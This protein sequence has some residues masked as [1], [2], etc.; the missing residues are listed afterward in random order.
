MTT[1]CRLE[2][3][4]QLGVDVNLVMFTVIAIVTEEHDKRP[5]ETADLFETSV[6]TGGVS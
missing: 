5:N 2:E 3:V 1:F 4:D 6:E